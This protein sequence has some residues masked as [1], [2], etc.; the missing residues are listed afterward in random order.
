M[1]FHNL[2]TIFCRKINVGF[3]TIDDKEVCIIKI[4]KGEYP[5]FLKTT[6][7]NGKQLE[8]FYVRSGN[9]SQ[10]INSLTEINNYLNAR[11]NKEK[12]N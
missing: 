11:F 3:I 1:I 2:L 7:K 10:E 4:T 9:S 8:K 6:D 5:L 12:N